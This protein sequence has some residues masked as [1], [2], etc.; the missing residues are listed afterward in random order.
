MILNK[1][2]GTSFLG[3]DQTLYDT[4]SGAKI[5]APINTPIK[6]PFDALTSGLVPSIHI[7]IY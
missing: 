1:H 3:V 7:T 2:Y 5:H 6:D 4:T